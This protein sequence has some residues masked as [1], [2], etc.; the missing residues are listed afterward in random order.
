MALIKYFNYAIKN[1]GDYPSHVAKGATITVYDS[2]TSNKSSIYE[3]SGGTVVKSNPFTADSSTGYFEFFV[4]RG[5]YDVKVSGTNVP[6][7]YTWS[8]IDILSSDASAENSIYNVKDYGAKG[9]G[10]TDDTTSIQN[11]INAADSAGGGIVFL[12]QGTYN[13]TSTLSLKSGIAFVG[14]GQGAV[15]LNYSG[16]SV[17]IDINDNGEW[18][19]RLADFCLYKASGSGTIGISFYNW[20]FATLERVRVYA[21]TDNPWSTAAIQFD[22][23]AGQGYNNELYQVDVSHAAIGI[24]LLN[25]ANETHMFGGRIR[26]CPVGVYVGYSDWRQYGVNFASLSTTYAAPWDGIGVDIGDG[27]HNS[28]VTSFGC[29]YENMDSAY[30]NNKPVTNDIV[31]LGDHISTNVTHNFATGNGIGNAVF[32]TRTND[33]NVYIPKPSIMSLGFELRLRQA[34][35]DDVRLRSQF[36]SSETLLIEN[37]TQDAHYISWDRAGTRVNLGSGKQSLRW[38]NSAPALGTWQQG[39]IVFNTGATAEGKVGWVCV[40]GGTPGTWKP[41][42]VI[43]A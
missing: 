35:Y 18:Y 31:C 17:A 7:T 13:I 33:P 14:A 41:F 40:S 22:G 25:N 6:Y 37:F 29:R 20:N 9:D 38:D 32:I 26:V 24:N 3:D 12:P 42:G 34:N 2:G 10:S 23:G 8:A 39:D 11:A 27:T 1:S 16:N 5:T 30:R 15:T 19:Y 4:A 36:S 21:T 28:E 43:D